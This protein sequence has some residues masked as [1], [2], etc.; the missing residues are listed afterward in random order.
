M[1]RPLVGFFT[2][3]FVPIWMVGCGA[4]ALSPGAERVLVT[5]NPA[6]NQCRFAGTLIGQQGNAFEGPFTSN[7]DLAQGAVN[8]LKNQAHAMGANYVVLETTTAG[9]TISGGPRSISGQQTDVTHM[10]NAFVCPSSSDA[11][12]PENQAAR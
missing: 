5:R 7:K 10:G 12:P 4:T 11:P 1:K 3:C 6:A 2:L 8:D 9:N